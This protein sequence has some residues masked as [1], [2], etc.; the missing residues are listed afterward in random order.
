METRVLCPFHRLMRIMQLLSRR[1][2][3][4]V[5]LYGFLLFSFVLVVDEIIV[6]HLASLCVQRHKEILMC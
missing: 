3:R 5:V 4:D 1:A 2:Q 6:S